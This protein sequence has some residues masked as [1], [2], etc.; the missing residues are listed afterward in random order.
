MNV[1]PINLREHEV[2]G[3]LDGRQTQL[4]RVV[5]LPLKDPLYGCEIAGCEINSLLGQGN[6][7][8]CPFG[9]PGD[10]LIGRETWVELLHTSP[11]T[12]Q[13]LLCAGDKLIEHATKRDDGR[14]NYDG[15]VIAYRATS[16]VEF[17]DGDGFSSPDFVNK[18][19]LPKWRSPVVMPRW[20]SRITLK[21]TGVRAQRLNDITEEEAK[22]EGCE[23]EDGFPKLQPDPSG[24]GEVGW[25][26]AIEWYSDTWQSI[27]GPDSWD[28]NP[29]V[30]VIEFKRV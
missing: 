28:A 14:W 6:H 24:I 19:D 5:K 13:P 11:A 7:Q 23:M 30:W 3:I 26:S 27:H 29:W 17:C 12:D 21:I 22:A 16:A 1:R 4:R 8:L 10:Q 18:D 9:K 25:D 2:C 20:A 15:R